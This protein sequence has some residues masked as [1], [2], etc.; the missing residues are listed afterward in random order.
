MYRV[1]GGS[2]IKNF[3]PSQVG[4]Y[5]I[6]L[7]PKESRPKIAKIL[8]GI[9]SKIENNNG[10]CSDLESMAK[11]LY[12]YWFVQF[13]FPDEN[14]KPYKSSGGKMVWNE[15]LKREIPAGWEV[16]SL[17]RCVKSINT[18]LNPRDNFKLNIGGRIK[19]LTVKNL[20]TD[21]IIDFSTCDFIDED[22]RAIVHKRSDIKIGDI[23]FASVAPLGRCAIIMDNP[24]N[25]DINE[26]VFSIRPKPGIVSSNYLYS[27][28]TSN[29][30]VKRAENTSTGSVFK[31]IRINDLLATKILIPN[32]DVLIQ[33][34]NALQ[35][36]YELKNC[37]FNENQ[38]LTSLRDFLLPMLMNGQVKVK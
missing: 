33:F 2:T 5:E 15:E 10:I 31:G 14:G 25:W 21:G 7:P 13:D 34:D 24:E 19:Y 16:F 8:K 12:D 3:A 18:G 4:E 20:T 23:L 9:D 26:S 28:F 27:I 6:D 17:S 30:F 37:H 29:E 1:A 35:K 11:L 36:Y 38:Q 32:K 22:A